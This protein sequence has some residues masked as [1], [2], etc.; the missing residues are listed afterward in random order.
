MTHA[1]DVL[2]LDGGTTRSVSR[3]SVAYRDV[4]ATPVA[5][6][7]QAGYSGCLYDTHGRIIA[8]SQRIGGIRG[9]HFRTVNPDQIERSAVSTETVAGR[10]LYLGTFMGHHYGHFITETLSTFWP[11]LQT[12]SVHFDTFVFHRFCFGTGMSPFAKDIFECFDIELKKIIIIDDS[13]L[14]FE[15][16]VLPNRLLALN[17]SVN[18]LIKDIHDHV[19]TRLRT[20]HPPS[21]RKFYLSRRKL[22]K[23]TRNRVI[24]N[25]AELEQC[26][27]DRGFQIIYPEEI[28]F[29]DQL[30]LYS[31]ACALAGPSGSALHNILF[32]PRGTEIIEL[33]DP[34]YC[35]R[36]APTQQLC[37]FAASARNTHIPY[38]G[39]SIGI[40]R[41]YYFYPKPVEATLCNLY[42]STSRNGSNSARLTDWAPSYL[43]RMSSYMCGLRLLVSHGLAIVARKAT[44][45]IG[46]A[47]STHD[48][49]DFRR[50]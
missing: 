1:D 45:L 3:T 25:E 12:S 41:A 46:R 31:H 34:R 32:C 47:L 42:S 37:D 33:G 50:Q 28:S 49:T 17:H 5:M 22:A 43:H 10:A 27:T 8:A 38:R 39:L 48:A 7:S 4:L 21:C 44:R 9:D 11:L 30:S 26:F 35:G 29:R 23:N 13:P 6:S 15:H 14:Q 40:R 20:D 19:A 16:I 24:V 36:R 18:R 2:S